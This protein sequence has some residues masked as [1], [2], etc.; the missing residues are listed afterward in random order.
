M[1]GALVR[2]RSHL[3]DLAGILKTASAAL[4]L[5]IES[6]AEDA[7]KDGGDDCK[8]N[9]NDDDNNGATSVSVRSLSIHV[10]QR[11]GA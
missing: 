4:A 10:V 9:D 2:V 7:D 8:D 11:S 5:K 6:L 3:F 1:P